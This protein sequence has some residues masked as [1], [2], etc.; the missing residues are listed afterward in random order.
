[1]SASGG[2]VVYR[3]EIRRELAA[4]LVDQADVSNMLGDTCLCV[5]QWEQANAHYKIARRYATAARRVLDGK[6]VTDSDKELVEPI[7][8]R[9]MSD[10][11]QRGH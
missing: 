10:I 1:M 2:G 7:R 11:G 6:N 4:R 5:C 3:P 8:N 9:V